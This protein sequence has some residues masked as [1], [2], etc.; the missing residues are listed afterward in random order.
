MPPAGAVVSRGGRPDLAGSALDEVISPTLL[1][2]GGADTVVAELNR[3][4]LTHLSDNSE[5]TIVPGATHLFEERGAL[6]EV[7]RLANE[8]FSTHLAPRSDA[9]S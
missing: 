9:G 7:M 3:E 1:I 4:A 2:V 5:M 8:W 6:E